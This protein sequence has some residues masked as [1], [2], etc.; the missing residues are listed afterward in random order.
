MGGRWGAVGSERRMK[1]CDG[2]GTGRGCLVL[3][4]G[5]YGA[6]GCGRWKETTGPTSPPG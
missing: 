4:I 5:F 6:G 2:E 3:R 1:E